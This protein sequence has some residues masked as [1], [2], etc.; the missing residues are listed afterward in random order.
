MV[1]SMGAGE[2]ARQGT[3]QTGVSVAYSPE[4]R[5]LATNLPLLTRI[6]DRTNGRVLDEDSA[7]QIF[8]RAGLPLAETRRPIWED[9][10]RLMLLLFLLDVAVRRIAIT[11]Q[12]I[13]TKFRNFMRDIAGSRPQ[14]DEAAAVLSNLKGARQQT[15]TGL[16]GRSET[17]P[18]PARDARYEAPKSDEQVSEELSQALGGASEVDQPVVARPTR[19]QPRVDEGQYTSRLLAAKKRAREQRDQNQD[20]DSAGQ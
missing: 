5:E 2:N 20:D 9:L 17:G 10:L 6:A 3:L 12:D 14:P 4:Y 16:T 18:T 7:T 19:K 13:A 1:Y 11:P 15:R 8:D